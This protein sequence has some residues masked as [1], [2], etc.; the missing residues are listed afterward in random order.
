MSKKERK[1]KDQKE[2]LKAPHDFVFKNTFC[3]KEA[4]LDFLSANLPC[5]LLY[6][7]DKEKLELTN[8]SYV[9]PVG[10]RGES[11]LV[12]KTNINGKEGY[13][14]ILCEQQS[15]ED[16]YM[17]LRFLEYNVQLLRQHLKENGNVLLP[18]ILNICI[19]NGKNPYKGSSSLLSMFSDPDLA[20][21]CMLDSFHLVDLYSTSEDELL[22]YKKA[23][24]AAMVLKKGIYRDFKQWFSDHIHLIVYLLEKGYI[25]YADTAFLYMLK[26]DDNPDLLETIKKSNPQL[27]QIAMSVAEKLIQQ[28]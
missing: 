4:M 1:E 26:V 6:K 15:T 9:D 21:S 19:Y 24:F 23:A 3:N 17:P 14:Y 22:S 18:A 11:D 2:G 8:K 13:L 12:F 20:K 10:R 25:S 27:K 28:G 7:I 16:R 5:D